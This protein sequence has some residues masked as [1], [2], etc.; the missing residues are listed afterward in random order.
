M[1]CSV[2]SVRRYSVEGRLPRVQLVERGAWKFRAKDVQAFITAGE[3]E[4]PTCGPV[5]ASCEPARTNGECRARRPKPPGL[6][7]DRPYTLSRGRGDAPGS[8]QGVSPG[9]GVTWSFIE[10]KLGRI[11][12]SYW[13]DDT[14]GRPGALRGAVHDGVE[15][16]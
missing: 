4:A 8:Y 14:D 16:A 7:P 15:D 11:S 13:V 3:L 2:K 6:T 12:G 5:C 1:R 9:Q 10:I